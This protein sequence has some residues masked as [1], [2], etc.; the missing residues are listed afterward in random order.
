MTTG[1]GGG[2]RR[3]GW[4]RA[5]VELTGLVRL[6]IAASVVTA[7]GGIGVT[8]ISTARTSLAP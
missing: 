5:G 6:L 1:G 7:F 2:H 4:H 3:A 8:V